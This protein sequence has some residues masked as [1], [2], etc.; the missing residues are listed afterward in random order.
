MTLA[1]G[2]ID[3]YD[4]AGVLRGGFF[5]IKAPVFAH[6][7]VAIQTIFVLVMAGSFAFGFFASHKSGFMHLEPAL[8]GQAAGTFGYFSGLSGFLFGF[9]IFNGLGGYMTVKNNYLGGYLGASTELMILLS[10]YFP[11]PEHYGLKETVVRWTM[12]AYTLM[13]GHVGDG[14][15]PEL[16]ALLEKRGLLTTDETRVVEKHGGNV[17]QILMWIMMSINS[18]IYKHG[19]KG[20]DLKCMSIEAK[21]LAQRS[22]AGNISTACSTYGQTPL[23]LVHLMSALVK[24]QLMLLALSEGMKIAHICVDESEGKLL[25]VAMSVVMLT[26]TPIIFQGLLEFVIMVNNPFGSDWVDYPISLYYQQLRDDLLLFIDAG[27]DGQNMGTV[28]QFSRG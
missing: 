13:C 16:M 6:P 25:Q 2:R 12:A 11:G 21:V 14:T 8:M 5:K 9:F 10:T 18:Q 4:L 22:G 17:V 28:E 1:D 26:V 15:F 27:D 24:I 19:L 23:P 3:G 20:A 7:F